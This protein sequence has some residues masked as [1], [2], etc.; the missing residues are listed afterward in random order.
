MRLRYLNIVLLLLLALA[1][2]VVAQDLVIGPLS[3][4][5]VTPKMADLEQVLMD[6]LA[7]YA[8]SSFYNEIGCDYS[9]RRIDTRMRTASPPSGTEFDVQRYVI[10]LT[11]EN[12]PGNSCFIFSN[13]KAEVRTDVFNSVRHIL[14]AAFEA[15]CWPQKMRI[16]ADAD[17]LFFMN[18]ECAH[19]KVSGVP[20]VWRPHHA[21]PFTE[22]EFQAMLE[23]NKVIYM[24]DEI[25]DRMTGEFS[26]QKTG[27][28]NELGFEISEYVWVGPCAKSGS[29]SGAPSSGSAYSLMMSYSDDC[30]ADDD[31]SGSKAISDYYN[32]VWFFLDYAE[33]NNVILYDLSVRGPY[34]HPTGKEYPSEIYWHTIVVTFRD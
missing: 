17:E 31:G 26:R 11:P 24:L 10:L 16:L 6:E 4:N 21:S 12:A 8:N 15:E 5:E 27:E 2:R 13:D 34:W 20:S 25:E 32:L 22:E 33:T 29:N 28:R 1:S 14:A 19:I 23:N 3:E 18:L 7:F 30:Y 9:Y